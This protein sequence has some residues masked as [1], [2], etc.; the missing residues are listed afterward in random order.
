MS[1]LVGFGLSLS[2]DPTQKQW[3]NLRRAHTM[4]TASPEDFDPVFTK[5]RYKEVQSAVKRK[6]TGPHLTAKDF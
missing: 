3:I 5:R 1:F 2:Q 6:V 4:S